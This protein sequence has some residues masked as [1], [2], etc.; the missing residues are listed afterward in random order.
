MK[1]T[2]NRSTEESPSKMMLKMKVFNESNQNVN[3]NSYQE[4]GSFEK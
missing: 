4:N 1:S 3:G 2:K